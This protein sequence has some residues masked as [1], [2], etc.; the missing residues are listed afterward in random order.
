MLFR[1]VSQSRYYGAN[2][3]GGNSLLEITA[4]GQKAGLNASD[5][6]KNIVFDEVKFDINDSMNYIS[7]IYDKENSTNLYLIKDNLSTNLFKN[8]GLFR[9]E[10]KIDEMIFLVEEIEKEFPKIGISDKSKV[11][12]KNLI[13]YLELKNSIELS[14]IIS[15]CAKQRK[16]SRGSHYRS[17]YQMLDDNYSKSSFVEHKESQYTIGFEDLI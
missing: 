9:D 3:L 4:F 2:R 5:K 11:Y 1:S 17:D 13:D 15:L 12:N 7:T 10:E 6:A 14:K 8:L 16:E